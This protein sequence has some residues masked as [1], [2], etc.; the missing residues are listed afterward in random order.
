MGSIP[1]VDDI[2]AG[3]DYLGVV[4]K[5][6]IKKDDIILMV[7]LDGTQLYASKQS[8]CWIYTWVVLNL[9]PDKRYKKIHVYLGGFIPG[10]NKPKNID[11]FLFVGLHHLA[12]L[13]HEGLRIWDSSKDCTF[14][15][16]LYLLFTTVDGP[17]LICW[18]GM[19][20]HSSKNGCHVY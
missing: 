6:N 14:S 18:D 11:L 19:V 13:Q 15:L 7:S 8:D 20:G 9:A 17:G 5:G 12:A 3:W 4:L 1:L 2:A 16:D 10:L